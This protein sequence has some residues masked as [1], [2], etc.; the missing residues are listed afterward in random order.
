VK[1]WLIKSLV[2]GI[3]C[4]FQMNVA[5]A[6]G[7][8]QNYIWDFSLPSILRAGKTARVFIEAWSEENGRTSSDLNFYLSKDSKLDVKRDTL[9]GKLKI[10]LTGPA[11]GGDNEYFYGTI[12]IPPRTPAG[13]HFFF[14][15]IDGRQRT[16]SGNYFS[17]RVKIANR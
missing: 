2:L 3:I 16:L 7:Y 17:R 9:I 12:K 4:S 5:H 10:N 11:S 6:Q 1:R 15:T 14:L 8:R 13:N